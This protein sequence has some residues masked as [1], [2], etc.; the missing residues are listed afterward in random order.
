[1]YKSTHNMGFVLFNDINNTN[2]NPIQ[3]PKK[4]CN[5]VSQS[6]LPVYSIDSTEKTMKVLQHYRDSYQAFREGLRS[7]ILQ[8][9]FLGEV[10]YWLQGWIHN[11]SNI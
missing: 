2:K 6:S 7:F 3:E 10:E 9:R 1:M 11:H 5:Q 4:T 8:L